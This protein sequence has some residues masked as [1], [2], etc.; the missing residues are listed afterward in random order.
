[1]YMLQRFHAQQCL[2]PPPTDTLKSAHHPA[3]AFRDKVIK[4]FVKQNL[5]TFIFHDFRS[6]SSIFFKLAEYKW[7]FMLIHPHRQK[8]PPRPAKVVAR[9]HHFIPR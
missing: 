4:I 8:L 1:M 6:F 3:L 9:E 7:Q 5:F 2:C